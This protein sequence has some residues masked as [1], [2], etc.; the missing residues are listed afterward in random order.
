MKPV[1]KIFYRV[2]YGTLWRMELGG[3]FKGWLEETLSEKGISPAKEHVERM[4][5]LLQL[6]FKKG[7]GDLVQISN[8]LEN[9]PFETAQDGMDAISVLYKG[10]PYWG[11][12]PLEDLPANG[13]NWSKY[14]SA[15]IDFFQLP[16]IFKAK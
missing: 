11:L 9:L 7:I 4:D 14:V 13:R 3:A 8:F 16:K 1:F 15:A 10:L 2:D 6:L 5:E 12:P